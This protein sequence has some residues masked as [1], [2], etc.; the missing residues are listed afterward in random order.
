MVDL[1]QLW[2]L[3]RVWYSSR[4]DPSAPRPNA[5]EIVEVFAGIGLVGDH[6]DPTAKRSG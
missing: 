3:A 6:W 1:P 4:L 2:D 5:S